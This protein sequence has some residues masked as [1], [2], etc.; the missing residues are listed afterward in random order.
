MV[1]LAFEWIDDTS[2]KMATAA[3]L[4]IMLLHL[5]RFPGGAVPLREYGVTSHA[6]HMPE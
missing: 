6:I 4:A 2:S 5:Q 1:S 3:A